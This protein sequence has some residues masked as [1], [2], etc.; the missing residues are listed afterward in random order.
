MPRS[1]KVLGSRTTL[2]VISDTHGLVRPEA[3]AALRGCD[4][5][6]HAGD[7]GK[8]EV[9]DELRPLAPLTAIRGN[10]DSWALGDL[11]ETAELTIAGARLFVIHNVNELAV[12]A[13]EA[14]YDAVISG[15]S[16]VP[17][18]ERANGV[19]YLNP[20]SAGPRRFKLP[21]AVAKL[22]IGEHGLEA[23]LIEL[24]VQSAPQRRAEV[25]GRRRS[26]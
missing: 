6:V 12:D 7:V 21:I 4:A 20:G 16:H 22:H 14:G 15:H 19:L 23:E 26:S 2:G 9:L 13:R 8:P 24:S 25:R 5:L 1:A 17:K 11:P 18:A 10:V 3:L